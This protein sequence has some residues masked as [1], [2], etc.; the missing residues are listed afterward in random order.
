[1]TRYLYLLAFILCCLQPA[2]AQQAPDSIDRTQVIEYFQDQQYEQAVQYLK[3]RLQP[4]NNKHLSLLGYAYYQWGRLPEAMNVYQQIL[5]LDSNHLQALQNLGAIYLQQENARAAIPYYRQLTT[6]QPRQAVYFRQLAFACFAAREP[7]TA[8]AYLRKAY[9]LNPHDSRVVARLGEEWVDRKE[10]ARADSVLNAYLITDSL[11]TS[12]IVPA[13]KSAYFQKGYARAIALGQRLLRH[14]AV[15]LTAY[16]YV[17]AAC[18]NTKAYRECINVYEFLNRRNLANE[19]IMYYAAISCTALKDY[20]RSNEL[21]QVCIDMAKSKS[22]DDYY[23]AMSANYEGTRSYK[24]ALACLDT[25][26][27]LFHQPLRQYSMGRIHDQHLQSPAAA[28]RHYERYLKQ[29]QPA[30][31]DE[32]SIYRYVQQKVK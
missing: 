30:D 11:Q 25:A 16:M 15:S 8:F 3:S 9:D 20:T 19:G 14:Q 22:L 12:V 27:Y 18:Y 23:S 28:R 13:I 24:K 21:L 6:L 1:M 26:Y 29:A 7:D 17:A 31:K 5:Q 2:R 10:Y 4:G 32:L